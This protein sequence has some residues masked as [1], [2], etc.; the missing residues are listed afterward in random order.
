MSGSSGTVTGA[1]F[2]AN[3][4]VTL[5]FGQSRVSL[6]SPCVSSASGA[7]NC[8]YTIPASSLG[9]QPVTAT[10]GATDAGAT[11]TV[12]AASLPSTAAVSG[13][14]PAGGTTTA[15]PAGG[16]SVSETL[17]NGQ[18]VTISFSA[19]SVGA[20]QAQLP[21]GSSLDIAFDSAPALPN[22]SA[23]SVGGGDVVPLGGPIYVNI[24]IRAADGSTSAVPANLAALALVDLALPIVSPSTAQSPGGIFVWLQAVYDQG[25][26]LGY[27]RPA[28]DFNPATGN[29]SLHLP[30]SSLEGTLILPAVMI[31][32]AVQNFDPNAHIFSSWAVNASDFGVAGPQFTTFTVVGP[33]VGSRVFVY[34]PISGNYGWLEVAGVG[35]GGLPG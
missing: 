12:T 9:S 34:D 7:F 3:S 14:A 6:D 17:A 1:G 18:P 22:A 32:A 21:A 4:G 19:A 28:A 20:I 33:Q 2:E 35:P 16:G 8:S 5:T 15:V 11:Y 13:P 30:I 29:L 23:M 25:A 10:T 26:F 27:V 24:F 31:P